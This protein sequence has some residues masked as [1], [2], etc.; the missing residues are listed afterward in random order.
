MKKVVV[1]GALDT[2]GLEFQFVRDQLEACGAAAFVIDTG[3]LGEPLFPPDITADEVA[4]AGGSSIEQLRQLNDRGTAIAV[5]TRGAAEIIIG[6]ERQG[7]VGGVFGMGGTAGTTVAASALQALPIGIP[8]LLVSTVASGNTRPYVGVKDIT[9]MY[10]VVDIAGLNRLSRRILSN[11]AH[12]L[13]G[14]VLNMVDE[15]EDDKVTL[16]I[17]MFGVTTPC[18]TRVREILE[19]QGYDLLVFHATGTGGLAMEELIKAGYIK[20]VA[21]ITT[22]EL[23]DELV[24]G[25]FSAG[26]NRLEA[27]GAVGIPQVVSVGALDMV[28]FGAPDTVPIQ[29]KERTFYQHNPT[30]TLMRTTVDENRELGRRLALKLSDATGPTIVVFPKKGVSL[31]DMDDKPF[32]GTE[33]RQALYEGM[34]Q[35]LRSDIR[36]VELE[37]HINDT[38]VAESIAGYLLELLTQKKEG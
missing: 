29:F 14:M 34:K 32:S 22:T 26:P 38:V 36:L 1:L 27:A 37:T 5:M 21:D 8:K 6:L 35:H 16:G 19:E 28:N 30:T 20:G 10:S 9:M 13:A 2:K 3:V 15:V 25:V 24:G 4:R 31:L 11:A 12:A 23:A 7:M 33:E 18:A 17:T